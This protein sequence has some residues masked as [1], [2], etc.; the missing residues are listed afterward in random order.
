MGP[1]IT[2]NRKVAIK[3]KYLEACESIEKDTF[4][5]NILARESLLSTLP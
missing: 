2:K 3:E 1:L 4:M 5:F